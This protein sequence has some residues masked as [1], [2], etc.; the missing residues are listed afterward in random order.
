MATKTEDHKNPGQ[1]NSDDLFDHFEQQYQNPTGS[2]VGED[3]AIDRAK[4]GN[5]TALDTQGLAE[6]ESLGGGDATKPL[7]KTSLAQEESDPRQ[8]FRKAVEATRAQKGRRGVFFGIGAA[9]GVLGI[10]ATISGIFSF[11]LPGILESLTGDGGKRLEK[12]IESRAEKVFIRYVLK[13]SSAAARNGNLILTGNPLGDLFANIRTSNFEAQLEATKGLKFEPGPNGTVKLIHNGSDLGNFNSENDIYKM[14]NEGRGLSRAD[15]RKIVRTQIPT[16][17]FLKRAKFVTWLALKYNVPRWGVKEIQPEQTEEAYNKEVAED[18][19]KDGIQTKTEIVEDAMNCLNGDC[20]GTDKSLGGA[21]RVEEAAAA[22]LAEGSE[23]LVEAMTKNTF[24]PMMTKVINSVIVKSL[25][26]AIPFVGEIE[27]A[28][29]VMMRM[30]DQVFDGLIQAKHAQYVLASSAGIGIAFAGVAGQNM[31]GD[32]PASTAGMFS[33]RLNGWEESVSYS[34]INNGKVVGETLPPLEKMNESIP[35]LEFGAI[36]KGIFIVWA[37]PAYLWHFSVSQLL[38]L[39]DYV[40]EEALTWVMEHT[41]AKELVAQFTPI[42]ADML[43]KVFAFLGLAIDPMAIGAKLAMYI[44]QSFLGTFNLFAK[45]MGMRLLTLTQ[46]LIADNEIRSERIADLAE[47]SFYD[48]IF[49]LDNRNSLATSIALTMPSG[50]STAF[51]L[52]TGSARLVARAPSN[53]AHATTAR[54]YAAQATVTSESLFNI[55]TYGGLPED[56]NAELD[57]SVQTPNAT[58]AAPRDDDFNHCIVDRQVVD[59]MDCV[60]V[61]CKDMQRASL[62][63]SNRLFADNTEPLYGPDMPDTSDTATFAGINHV[64]FQQLPSLQKGTP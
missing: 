42:L 17:R 52:A 33:D 28:V 63:G 16:W 35:A 19:V 7:T 58:C 13:G 54:A 61:K 36:G 5:R 59:S 20:S 12:V 47:Q 62:N 18:Y 14:F 50:G 2:P 57:P 45:E 10:V 46:A 48:R 29:D 23:E 8:Q 22:G 56:L 32:L 26:L 55:K 1:Q 30:G 51:S 4:A 6:A 3:A 38:D 15:L 64:I 43:D 44:H 25:T 37:A 34:L 40:G 21:E 27:M 39:A 49:N 9:G 60:F 24:K 41:S 31:A 11:K 53:F